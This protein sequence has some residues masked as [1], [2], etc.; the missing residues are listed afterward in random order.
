MLLIGRTTWEVCF[1]QSEALLRCGSDASSYGISTL[2]TQTSIHG[3]TVGGVTKCRL[4]SQASLIQD[5]LDLL[6]L[7][8]ILTVQDKGNTGQE[9]III[10]TNTFYN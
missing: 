8:M 5:F 9:R 2:V 4:F 6:A 3:D 1:N 10:T 7:I